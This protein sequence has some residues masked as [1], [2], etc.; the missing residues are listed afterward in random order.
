MTP[1][2]DLKRPQPQPPRQSL[3]DFLDGMS[4]NDLIAAL[5]QPPQL[6]P[7][8]SDIPVVVDIH[9]NL[10]GVQLEKNS[11]QT[12]VKL[13]EQ[14]E[15]EKPFTFMV[16][17]YCGPAYI[18]AMRT[19]LSRARKYARERNYDLGEPFRMVQVSLVN[20]AMCDV[21]T[22]M[23]IPK[24]KKIQPKLEGLAKLLGSKVKD[25][26]DEDDDE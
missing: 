15:M 10:S 16:R 1:V 25:Y 22:L 2:I 4:E 17:K 5:D 19:E 21:V 13:F 8:V 9:S 6:E 26:E 18:Q 14:A 23:R 20:Q 7:Q 11:R 24:G 12:L 3:S